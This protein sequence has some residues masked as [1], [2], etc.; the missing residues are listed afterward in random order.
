[1]AHLNSVIPKHIPTPPTTSFHLSSCG[2]VFTFAFNV[3][4]RLEGQVEAF[5]GKVKCWP[6][7]P[8]I[9]ARK[10]STAFALTAGSSPRMA[11]SGEA[12]ALAPAQVQWSSWKCHD[13]IYGYLTAH[14]TC[15]RVRWDTCSERQWRRRLAALSL[16]VLPQGMRTHTHR[17]TQTQAATHAAAHTCRKTHLVTPAWSDFWGLPWARG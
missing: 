1:M 6:K 12:V 13:L 11:W 5:H 4:L 10:V 9:N 3:L 16:P 15:T 7:W 14:I 8:S 17:D 2:W